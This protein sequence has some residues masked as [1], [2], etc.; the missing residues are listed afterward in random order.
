LEDLAMR[1]FLAACL[2]IVIIGAAGYF[3]LGAMQ[4]PAGVAYST[5]A[6]RINPAL[7][8]RAVLSKNVT[9]DPTTHQCTSRTASQWIFV[10]LRDPR[11][12]PALCSISQ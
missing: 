10:D 7:S 8:W 3:S 9:G 5:S 6:V 4:Q 11:G 2:A 1:P 12:E